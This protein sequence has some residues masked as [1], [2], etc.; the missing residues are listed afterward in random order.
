MR[1]VAFLAA[2]LLS[3]AA[4]AQVDIKSPMTEIRT[5]CLAEAASANEVRVV[6][7]ESYFSCYGPTAKS[8]YDIA[9]DERVVHDKNGIF[10]ARYYGETGYCAHQIEDEAGKPA[11]AYI[12][13]VV[14]SKP[15]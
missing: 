9:T 5:R 4:F 11:S 6:N 12:C 15:Q 1:G 3:S 13:E 2:G 14:V 8:W 10:I 7:N